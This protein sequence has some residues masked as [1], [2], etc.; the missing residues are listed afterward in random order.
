LLDDAGASAGSDAQP[1]GAGHAVRVIDLSTPNSRKLAVEIERRL[2]ALPPGLQDK[3]RQRYRVEKVKVA[4]LRG[5]GYAEPLHPK[6]PT[7]F[8]PALLSDVARSF[9]ELS[10]E[11]A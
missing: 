7:I 8:G 6:V 10:L 1:G 4:E 2:A 3:L 9:S 11:K 5:R